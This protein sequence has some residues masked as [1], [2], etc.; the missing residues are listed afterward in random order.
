MQSFAAHYLNVLHRVKV[1]VNSS[2]STLFC[3]CKWVNVSSSTKALDK[4][5]A[6]GFGP[7][8]W[9]RRIDEEVG[10]S[11]NIFP[12]HYR[13][14]AQDKLG[15]HCLLLLFSDWKAKMGKVS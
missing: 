10:N 3:D 2:G 9:I 4:G 15:L 6:E 13:I 5:P 8:T 1:L 11:T 7:S 14:E 12:L